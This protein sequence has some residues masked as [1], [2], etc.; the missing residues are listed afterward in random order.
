MSDD[1]TSDAFIS[2]AS[3]DANLANS[4]LETLEQRGLKCWIAPRDVPAGTLYADAIVRAINGAKLFLLVLSQHSVASSH[5]SKELERASSKRRK[6][7]VVRTDDA[8]LTP[9]YEYF[10][11][12]SQWIELAAGG[13]MP[14]AAAKVLEAAQR[15][16]GMVPGRGGVTAGGGAAAVGLSRAVAGPRGAARQKMSLPVAALMAVIVVALGYFVIDK[17]W[18]SKRSLGATG[19]STAVL[20]DSPASAGDTGR[21]S[22]VGAAGGSGV[23]A[24]A[25]AGTFAPPAHSIAVLPFVNMSGDPAQ[26]YFS[27]GLSEEL[28][29]SLVTV[30]DLQVAARTSSFSFKGKNLDVADIARKLNV[31]AVLEGSVRKDGGQVRITAQLI[32]ATTGFHLWSH[33]YDRD[34]KNVLALQTEIATAVTQALQAS[35]LGEAA[36]AIDVGGTQV[37][38]AFDAY[39]RGKN[40]MR[41]ELDKENVQAVMA[42]FSEAIRLDPKFAKALVGESVAQN[43]FA[44]NFSNDNEIGTLFNRSREN[45]ERA[46]ALAPD[47][48]EAHSALA[49]AL[50]RGSLDFVRAQA[51]ND[52]A[53]A[54]TPNDA[55]VLIRAGRFSVSMGRIDAGLSNIRK[56][57]ALD[58]LNPLA[59][60]RLTYAL[61]DA[62]RHREA[63][64]A[65]DRALQFNP[66]S[67]SLINAQGVEYLLLG[68]LV[69][70]QRSCATPKRYWVGQFC[71]AIVYDRLH[72]RPDA[73]AE[74]AAMKK[75]LGIGAA[76]QYAVI[77][78]QWGDTQKALDWLD[79]AYR[80]PDPGIVNLRTDELVDPL[81]KEPRFKAIEAKLKFPN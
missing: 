38:A 56:A 53:L 46:I 24:G 2:Y 52:R 79:K 28:L 29:N 4:F 8:P 27:D 17:F 69:A 78:A 59:Y 5:V 30:R 10:L 16:S 15:L 26:D 45:A 65:A 81:R 36:A 76:Y 48:G 50:E 21:G 68:D 62:R 20:T 57:I 51:E 22:G 64:E 3:E 13:G 77:Y 70:A 31:G 72:R 39:L 37:P 41:R 19:V 63:I 35:L 6:V 25:A 54:L 49:N 67:T 23:G 73:E 34:L 40:L 18:L 11:S 14:A 66:G 60:A 12:E 9:A 42:A 80:L 7:I 55:E 1:I 33:T 71:M 61:S 75:D 74:I 47:L 58:P 32:N 43:I 44:S